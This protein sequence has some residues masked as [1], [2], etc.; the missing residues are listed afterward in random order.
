[1]NFVASCTTRVSYHVERD[2]LSF[3]GQATNEK[4][5][6]TDSKINSKF[7]WKNDLEKSF[8]NGGLGR[9]HQLVLA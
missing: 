2:R 9:K 6:K 8:R 7:S 3:R 1:M 4:T 5:T